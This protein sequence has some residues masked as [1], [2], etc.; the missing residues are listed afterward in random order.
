V[1]TV[2]DI[3]SGIVSA[4]FLCIGWIIVGAIAGAV[5]RS[6]MGSRDES[7][8]SDMIL[9]LIGA[10]V[11]GFIASLLGFYRPDGGIELVLVNLA[12]AIIGAIILIAIGRALFGGGR[13]TVP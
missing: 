12:L 1:D 9:G 10:V 6:L 11:G 4:P 5:A 13:R 2:G 8:L 3:I 7:F